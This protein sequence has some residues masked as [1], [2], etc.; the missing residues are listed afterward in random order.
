M[1]KRKYTDQQFIDAINRN[2]SIRAV[3]KDLG[4]A[5]AGGSYKLL[6][7]RVKKLGLD[8]S[9]FTGQA[10]MKGKNHTWAIKIPLEDILTENSHYNSNSLRIRLIKEGLLLPQC[11]TSDCGVDTWLGKPIT[12][13]LDHI[14]GDNTNNRIEN[15]R[16]LCPNCHSQTSTYCGR[17]KG[18]K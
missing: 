16:L 9:H 12:L 6:H 2:F 3:L 1:T 14:D 10:H 13:H 4:L 7:A 8:T 11:S 17:N 15:L 18:K 5:P